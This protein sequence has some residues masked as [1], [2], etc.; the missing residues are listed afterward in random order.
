MLFVV[1][2]A[3]FN[4]LVVVW[5]VISFFSSHICRVRLCWNSIVSHSL[6]IDSYRMYYARR[7]KPPKMYHSN[8]SLSPQYFL[9]ISRSHPP[10]TSS[11]KYSKYRTQTATCCRATVVASRRTW[12][13]RGQR[14]VRHVRHHFDCAW[15]S[16]NKRR[17]VV[18]R[19]CSVAA[20][21]AMPAATSSARPVLCLPIQKLDH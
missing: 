10:A 11:C 6:S 8:S 21:L 18:C 5:R 7:T 1:F 3:I 9:S 13:A 4:D 2:I 17:A 14:A 12:G 19:A 16:I 20:P 15:K